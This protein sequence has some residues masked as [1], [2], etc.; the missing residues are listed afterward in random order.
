LENRWDC[1]TSLWWWTSCR[2]SSAASLTFFGIIPVFA[3][4]LSCCQRPL[5]HW[6]HS[7]WLSLLVRWWTELTTALVTIRITSV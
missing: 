1:F 3:V 2:T 6:H 7:S 4:T 5:V